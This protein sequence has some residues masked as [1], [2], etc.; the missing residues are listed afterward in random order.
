MR[1]I[2][3]RIGL[4]PRYRQRVRDVPGR[5]ASP[6]WV[7]DAGF[8]VTYHVRRSA[9]PRPGSDDQL[10][11]L[12]AR[13]MSRKLD[14]GRP[15]WEMYL[16]EGLAGDRFAIISKTHHA[17]V[18]GIGSVEIG[19]VMLDVA[20]TPREVSTPEWSPAREPSA[21]ELVGSA[22]G[23]LMRR[24]SAFVDLARRSARDVRRTAE[25]LSGTLAMA[26]TMA[27]QAPPSPLNVTIGEGRRFHRLDTRLE[28]Y[29]E[30]RKA[31]GGT[32]NDVVLAVVAGALRAWLMTRGEP[33]GA[34]SVLRAMVPVSVRRPGGDGSD[35]GSGNQIASYL[36][37]LPIGEASAVVRLQQVSYA[38]QAHKDSGQAVGA[39]LLAGVAGFTP[40]TIHA[41]AARV[42]ADWS[43]RVFNL[44]VTNV[45]GP[46]RP[47]YAAGARLQSAYP[48]V[49]LAAGQ[50]LTIGLTSYDGCVFYGLWADR[51]AMPDIEVLAQCLEDALAQ[52]VE[53][54]RVVDDLGARGGRP[55]RDRRRTS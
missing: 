47:L 48:V 35:T 18:D 17:M 54:A 8:D 28:D 16:V 53:E 37:D 1:L 30:V 22:V 15:L 52:L 25:R 12:V 6:V 32:V 21:P 40:P 3:A 4:V 55:A 19:Q 50:A 13:V 14:R 46:Q 31:F 45:P 9:L 24:P 49:P 42:A 41:G 29:R 39:V 27:R 7:D 5:L 11:D 34:R 36:I 26:R 10:D 33:V 20:P 2:E 38:M 43:R 23:E 44:V 51:D